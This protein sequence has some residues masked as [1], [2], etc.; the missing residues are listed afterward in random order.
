MRR[1]AGLAAARADPSRT[2]GNGSET[3]AFFSHWP[4]EYGGLGLDTDRS[5]VVNNVLRKYKVPRSDNPLGLNVP[6]A[7]LWWGTDAQ[8]QRFLPPILKQKEIWVQLFSEPGAGSDLA[9]LSHVLSA[10]ATSGTSTVRRS[11]RATPSGRSGG[12]LLARTDPDV[13]KHQ[14]ISMFV[15]DMNQPDIDVRPS[16]RSRASSSSTR[17]SSTTRCPRREPA[18]ADRGRLEAGQPPADVRAGRGRR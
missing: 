9:G 7:L 6:R 8:K 12:I 17:C 1:R 10:M 14:G 13:P 4:L 2:G 5:T 3:S 16:N 18:R 15:I 11:G